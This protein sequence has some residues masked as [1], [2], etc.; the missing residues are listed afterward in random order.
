MVTTHPSLNFKYGYIQVVARIPNAGHLWPA[1][2]LDP[3]NYHWPP[4]IDILEHWGPP[5]ESSGMFFHPVSGGL[6]AQHMTLAQYKQTVGWQTFALDWTPSK[7]TWYLNGTE[8]FS[9]VQAIPHQKMFLIANLA[10]FNR[11]ASSSHSSCS[12]ATMEIKSVKVWQ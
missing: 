12:S 3:S 8:V 9:V 1:L 4:E 6:V 2:W 7:L 10:G 11:S 5:K